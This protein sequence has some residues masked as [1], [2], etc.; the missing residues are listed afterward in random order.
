MTPLEDFKQQ[1]R[2]QICLLERQQCGEHTGGRPARGRE[3][4]YG[5]TAVTLKRSDEGPNQS[6]NGNG[7]LARVDSRA[8]KDGFYRAW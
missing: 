7:A 5:A 2:D 1:S 4:S 3:T 8:E 6:S